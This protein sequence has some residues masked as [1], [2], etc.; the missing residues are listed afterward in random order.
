MTWRQLPAVWDADLAP[1]DKLVLL[2]LCKFANERGRGARPAQATISRLTGIG[3]R[4]VRTAL[5]TLRQRGLIVAEGKGRRGTINYA[6]ALPLASAKPLSRATHPG[7]VVP[8]IQ[9]TYPINRDSD[10]YSN[11]P[12]SSGA[13]LV[14][15]F[16]RTREE[17]SEEHAR[18]R[19]AGRALIAGNHRP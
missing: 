11:S 9:G 16:R 13:P 2:C 10:S 1:L 4:R 14:R 15:R 18:E 17:L 6:I 19:A 7:T 3:P 5:V 12:G 8:T